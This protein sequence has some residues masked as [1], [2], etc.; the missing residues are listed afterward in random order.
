MLLRAAVA[1]PSIY[2]TQPWQFAVVDDRIELYLDVGRGLPVADPQGRE[3]II[4]CG[5]ALEGLCLGMSHLGYEPVVTIRAEW[6]DPTHLA[7]I[8]RG[9]PRPETSAEWRRYWALQRRHVYRDVSRVGRCRTLSSVTCSV[10][11]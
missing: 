3:Q 6:W 8:R 10:P 9:A 5:A 1:A 4:S 7:T 11:R 2:N